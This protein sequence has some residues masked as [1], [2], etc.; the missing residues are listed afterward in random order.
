MTYIADGFK[1][2]KSTFFLTVLLGIVLGGGEYLLATKGFYILAVTIPA[3][4]ALIISYLLITSRTREK[5]TEISSN[6]KL[7]IAMLPYVI[8][9][10]LTL[11]FNLITPLKSALDR[12][13]LRL[14]FPAITTSLGD[15]TTAG[16]G[17]DIKLLN[18]PGTIIFLSSVISFF[19]FT[20]VGFLKNKDFKTIIKKT[21]RKST[22]TTIAIFS[23]VG[24]AMIMAHTQMTGI[25]AQGI[26]QA[27]NQNL[28]PL[29]SPFIGAIGAFITGSSNNSIVLFAALQMRTAELL[30]LSVPL[31]LAAQSA[32]GALGGMMA[33][34]KV[35]LGCA[36]VGLERK[37]GE[38]IGKILIYGMGLV[39][40]I[41]VLTL[42]FSNLGFFNAN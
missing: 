11:T 25:L 37:E 6:R 8:L 30:G 3:L 13:F 9:V 19:I 4:A 39:A 42:L 23:M 1:G 40:L 15:F 16:P 17:R 41:G 5:S 32:G 38:V 29:I 33:P 2:I 36:T 10:V 24:I 21:A 12:Y 28:F 35:I 22:D 31:I 27:I 7:L 18:H 26:S 20:K 34:A 14:D